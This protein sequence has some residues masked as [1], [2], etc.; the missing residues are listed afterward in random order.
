MKVLVVGGVAGGASAAARLRRL[1][2]KAEI[3]MFEKGEY[4]SFANCGLP[5]YIGGAISEREKLLVQTP[6][7]M[8]AR[9][10]I[11]VRTL[12]E[13]TKIN[14]EE[15][16][17]EVLDHRTGKTY[18]ESYDYLILSPG[19]E[20]IRPP[21][22]GIDHPNIFTLRTVPDT[23]RIKEFILKNRPRNAVVV[24][25][26]F[27]GIEMTE[28]LVEAGLGVTLVEMAPQVMTM[29]DPEMA[30]IIHNHL[31]EHGVDLRLEDG[32]KC[33]AKTEAGGVVV[34]LSSGAEIETDMVILAIGVRPD[35]RL[36]KDAGLRIG[37]RGG[38]WVDEHLR[39]SDPNIYAV[40]DAIEVKDYI[41][42]TPGLIPLA[43]PAN[44]QGRIAADN[45]AGRDVTYKGTQGTAIAKVFDLVVASTGI[46]QRTLKSRGIEHK[47]VT[48]HPLSHAGYYPGGV[49]MALKVI[50]APDGQVLG[51]QAVGPDGVDKRID[52]LATVIR[53]RKSVFDLEELELAYA[54]PFGSAKD[55]VNMAGFVA[56]NVLRG[57][58]DIITWDEF[59]ALDRGEV[60]VLDVRDEIE[61]ELGHIDGAINIPVNQLRRRLNE[62]PKDKDI[63]VYCA[64]GLRAYIAYRILVQNGFTRVKNLTGGY[65]TLS[66]VLVDRAARARQPRS[67]RSTAGGP[68][69]GRTA[70]QGGTSAGQGSGTGASG[71]PASAL[72]Q[73]ERTV[74]AEFGPSPRQANEDSSFSEVDPSP[75]VKGKIVELNACGLQCPGPIMQVFRAMK[76]LEE[77]DILEVKATDPGFG[78]DI[79]SWCHRTGNTLLEIKKAN[80]VIEARIMRGR[81][82]PRAGEGAQGVLESRAAAPG[83]AS[84]RAEA[85][86]AA[87]NGLG[88]L[89]IFG[90]GAP[91]AVFKDDKTIVVFSG[92]LDKAIASF[93]IANGA[94]AM[95]KKVT[96]FFTFWGLN[97]LR[98][99]EGASVKK[100]L[101]D[102]MFG[103]MM[104]RGST[105]LGL[106][107][108]NMLGIGPKMIRHVMRKKNVDSLEALIGQAKLAGVR[109]VACQMSMDVMG[110][111]PEELID[112]VEIGGVATYLD[113][114]ED[115]NVNLFI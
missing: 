96:M 59:E 80:G 72:T 92:D 112:G 43:G 83:G 110:I 26:G 56:S 94:A 114:A 54:P 7:A 14:R 107:R 109:L 12:S 86:A 57:Q 76:D 2:E 106:S 28:N 67:G 33:F 102:R 29:M 9:F 53:F 108:M 73:S 55:P 22:P 25:G 49:P 61:Y 89:A 69:A 74:R 44:K 15:K 19:A 70:A 84:G 65:K 45:I 71:R 88:D 8:R 51:A 98:K 27:I 97:I 34:T 91:G 66:E 85:M 77:G 75:K 64:V 103:M 60:A 82:A 31:R 101:L 11:D 58:L 81:V 1:D 63:V 39:T 21:I 99:P 41:L 100:P 35:T 46:S 16:T 78:R 18:K 40:G 42:G 47:A 30:A 105:R 5:Y 10:N 104:P 95:G 32:V 23:D 36:A 52:V 68:G 3:I 24:G 115:S 50:F 37:E 20:P 4:I 38:I 113:A 90:A 48:I 87:G 62:V 13:V 79:E 93:I 6:E 111:K 17:V